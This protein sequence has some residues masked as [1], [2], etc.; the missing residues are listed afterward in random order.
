MNKVTLGIIAA[1]ILVG[2]VFLFTKDTA[3]APDQSGDRSPSLG[4]PAPHPEQRVVVSGHK[5]QNGNLTVPVGT[6]VIFEN[7]DSFVGLPY[8]SHTITTGAIDPSGQS[9]VAGVVPNSGSGVPDGLIDASL[10]RGDEFSYTFALPG[11]VTFYV[12]EHPLVAGEG[13]ITITAVEETI[14]NENGD[15]AE[16]GVIKIN[17]VSFS[18]SPDALNGKVGEEIN[19]DITATGQHTFTI[20][21]LGVDVVTP[22]RE[23]TRI[24][25]TPDR[26]GTFEYYCAIPGHKE[27]GQVGTINVSDT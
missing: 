7:R 12:A 13:T 27:A 19:I 1:V 2:V 5:I 23:T 16:D 4:T 14:I 3:E 10:K 26:V 25:F 24:S 21:E 8:S 11:T 6:T 9:G 17:A 15:N 22:H 20:D 18:F